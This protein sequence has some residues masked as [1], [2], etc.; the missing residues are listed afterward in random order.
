MNEVK[1]TFQKPG[2]NTLVQDSGR[3]GFQM[4]GVPVGGFMDSVSAK[5]ANLLV[6]NAAKSPLFEITL[7]GPEVLINGPCQLALTGA[8]ISATID[9][10]PVPMYETVDVGSRAILS[11]GKLK[12]GCRS[13]LAFNGSL[14]LKDWLGSKSAAS[15]E[16]MDLTPE[17]LIKRG[18]EFRL[19][20]GKPVEKRKTKQISFSDTE[21]IRILPGPEYNNFSGDQLHFF[22]NKKFTIGKDSNRMGY[23]LD[24]AILDFKNDKEVISSPIVPGTIQVT[25]SAKPI[26]LMAD[27]QTSGGYPR[28]ANIIHADLSKVAQ[29]VPGNKISFKLCTLEEALQARNRINEYID[30][31]Q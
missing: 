7:M 16:T 15:F 4:F 27:A 25:N 26:I 9:G 24:D 18:S 13:Y 3:S 10:H 28:I 21:E 22:L 11:F 20:K 1:L 8:D 19:I 30:S 5:A 31:I 2:M 14:K 6:G 12:A 29:L 23:R 17:S